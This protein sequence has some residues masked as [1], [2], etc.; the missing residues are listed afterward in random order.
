MDMIGITSEEQQLYHIYKNV[1][2][3]EDGKKVLEDLKHKS[4]YS[5]DTIY[6]PTNMYNTAFN[7]GR[8]YLF[9][10]IEKAIKLGNLGLEEI[11]K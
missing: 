6:D 10:Q 3:T 5:A 9:K 4:C 2:S 1:F 8:M 11:I 7:A